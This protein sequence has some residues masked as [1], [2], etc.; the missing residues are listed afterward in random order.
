VED[1]KAMKVD[2]IQAFLRSL[3]G[4]WMKPEETVD[5]FKAGNPQSEVRGIAVGWMSYKWALERAQS[6]G[7]NVFITHE[8][9]FYDHRDNQLE[10]FAM[11]RVRQKQKWIEEN[12]IVILRCHDLWDQM[13][14]I[15]IPD[16]WGAFLTLGDAI[17]GEG[18]FRIYDVSGKTALEVAQHVAGR[19][20]LV[21]QQAVQLVGLADQPVTRVAIGT[22]AIT[23]FLRFVSQY[24][25]DLAICSDD[26]TT[27]WRD[28]AFAIDMGISLIIVN[29]PVTEEA[30]M[31]NLAKCLQNQFPE[32]PVHHI[33]QQCMYRLVG[34]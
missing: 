13:P 26:G 1:L 25:V 10:L 8:P 12:G 2:E 19:V 20:A 32:I 22:G 33:G 30:G 11:D 15:G 16:S 21:G 18:Y 4:G 7:C 27:Y 29:H 3:N 34:N 17:D 14:N 23:P 24:N 28:A 9:T 31:I 6:L 5:T